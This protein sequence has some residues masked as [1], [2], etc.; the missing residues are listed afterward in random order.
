MGFTYSFKDSNLALLTKQAASLGLYAMYWFV[1]GLF[2]TGVWVIACV[3]YIIYHTSL[4]LPPLFR[5]E[6]G[7]QSFSPSKRINNSV[8][9]LF[10][11]LL[12]VPYH[13]WRIS[14]SSTQFRPCILLTMIQHARHHA[15]TGHL[16]R[17]EV[18]VPRTRKTKGFPDAMDDSE[19][20]GIKFVCHI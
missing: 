3:L 6:A 17:D 9:W 2:A 16:T 7:H 18:F 15:A 13:S 1:T 11:S 14:V 10:H 4:K 8:G 20:T 5:H 12:L 19:A